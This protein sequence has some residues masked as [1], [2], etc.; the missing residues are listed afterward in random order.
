LKKID[1]LLEG[2]NKSTGFVTAILDLEGNI[3]SKSGWRPICTEFHRI[4]PETSKRCTISD[5]A[6]ANK[7]GEG[8]TYHYY[9][10]LN[11][12]VDVAVPIVIDGEHIAN[13][14]SGQFFFEEPDISF[15]NKQAKKYGFDE[16]EYLEALS[17]VPVVSEQKVK[18]VMDFLLNMTHMI[19]DLAFQKAKQV[20]LNKLNL[21]MKATHDGIFDWN[22]ESN[23]IYYS[24]SMEENARDTRS[25]S[26]RMIFRCG[27]TQPIRRM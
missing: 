11:G 4:N 10:C 15:F 12:L 16:K 14:F 21:A 5:T 9:K 26:F 13:L 6:L 3:V 24:T 7:M 8:E 2:F 27:K 17:M 19:S 20:E 18:T 25:M 1:T 23:V 22:L